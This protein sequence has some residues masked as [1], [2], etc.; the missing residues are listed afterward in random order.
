MLS[1]L[2]KTNL[3]VALSFSISHAVD[4]NS[5]DKKQHTHMKA[6]RVNADAPHEPDAMLAQR[7]QAVQEQD[8]TNKENNIPV[9]RVRRGQDIVNQVRERGFF[10]DD[11]SNTN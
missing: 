6:Y 4:Q 5:E 2:L 7:A 10:G 1:I 8:N 11:P 9:F 3:L